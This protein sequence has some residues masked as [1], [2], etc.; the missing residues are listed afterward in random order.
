MPFAEGC[1]R[2]T[3]LLTR[4]RQHYAAFDMPHT[5]SLAALFRRLPVEAGVWSRLTGA[6]T[7]LGYS[8]VWRKALCAEDAPSSLLG[9][10]RSVL[11]KHVGLL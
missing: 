7:P 9:S 2:C 6:L 1:A 5:L 11:C 4:F 8:T 3:A 10:S